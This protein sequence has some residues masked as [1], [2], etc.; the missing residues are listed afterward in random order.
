MDMMQVLEP[1]LIVKDKTLYTEQDEL[2]EVYFIMTGTY[3]IG[4]SVNLERFYPMKYEH[5]SIIGAYGVTFFRRSA[6]I[7]RTVTECKAYFIRRKIWKTILER[8]DSNIVEEFQNGIEREFIK[9]I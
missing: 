2:T 5:Y 7:Y 8:S 6:Y 9:K 4:F 1:I 3:K